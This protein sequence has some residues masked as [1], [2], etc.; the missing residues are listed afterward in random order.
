MTIV[1]QSP[2]ASA[3]LDLMIPNWDRGF[4]ESREHELTIISS[5]ESRSDIQTEEAFDAGTTFDWN[6]TTLKSVMDHALR[7]A[8]EIGALPQLM[9]LLG[10]QENHLRELEDWIGAPRKQPSAACLYFSQHCR[11][12]GKWVPDLI[13]R[14]GGHAI[15]LES[16]DPDIQADPRD[17]VTARPDVLFVGCS[18]RSPS[19]DVLHERV[20]KFLEHACFTGRVYL[21]D[22]SEIR[23]SGPSLYDMVFRLSSGLYPDVDELEVFRTELLRL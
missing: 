18:A 5:A 3:W 6:P 11:L 23:A 17:L 8:R 22:M 4:F 9:R 14:A 10:D 21:T 7:L 20:N 16:G 2:N 19:P 13:E 1:S 15:L 12:L